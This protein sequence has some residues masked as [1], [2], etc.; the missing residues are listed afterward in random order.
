MAQSD[1][2]FKKKKGFTVVGNAAI[3]DDNLSPEAK[4][5]YAMIQSWITYEAEN[6]VCSKAFIFAKSGCGEKKFER[7]WNELK[8][9]GY[10]KMYCAPP[11]VW[12][13]ELLDEPRPEIAHTFYLN[14]NGEINS[15]NI[16]RAEKKAEKE[17]KIDGEMYYPQKRSNT[18]RSNT[19]S[20]N[21]KGGNHINTDNKNFLI[22]TSSQSFYQDA[23][24]S[25]PL[26]DGLIDNAL[27]EKVK[28]DIGAKEL[29]EV[30]AIPAEE[31]SLA[32]DVVAELRTTTKTQKLDG[33]TLSTEYI[34]SVGNEVNCEHI[35]HVFERLHEGSGKIKNIRAYVR[36]AILDAYSSMGARRTVSSNQQ[37]TKK[38]ECGFD[39]DSFFEAACI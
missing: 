8:V 25:G 7:I 19:K 14:S 20:S 22:N 36:T 12:S 27:L 16:D 1:I 32:V 31:V 3:R 35:K 21:T 30:H 23:T 9:A 39:L 18:K 6:F 15:T 37:S 33:R 38:Q 10:L 2:I 28:I 13:A 24:E 26:K 4:G 34:H 5:V 29:T 17:G 11:A